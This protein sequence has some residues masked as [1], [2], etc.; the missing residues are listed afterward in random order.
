MLLEINK[1]ILRKYSNFPGLKKTMRKKNR[2]QVKEVNQFALSLLALIEYLE[3]KEKLKNNDIATWKIS[4]SLLKKISEFKKRYLYE[5]YLI[6]YC[7]GKYMLKMYK[8]YNNIRYINA[9]YYYL[10]KA[11]ITVKDR[12]SVEMR[13]AGNMILFQEDINT[14]ENEIYQNIGFCLNYY[15]N[16]NARYFISYAGAQNKDERLNIV[17][18]MEQQYAVH[19]GDR[20]KLLEIF[21][22]TYNSVK[23]N[24]KIA[25]KTKNIYLKSLAKNILILLEKDKGINKDSIKEYNLILKSLKDV[26]DIKSG[27][28]GMGGGGSSS[29]GLS[30]FIHIHSSS[31]MV[32]L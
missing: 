15:K 29:E 31:F 24:D 3:G 28:M 12:E 30:F 2:K 27:T 10:N 14:L 5:K 6:N 19:L 23:E 13:K 16:I 7:K 8:K 20:L 21:K 9:A 17:Y 26:D 1:N 4:H 11:L 18:F 32:E 25:E 22:K